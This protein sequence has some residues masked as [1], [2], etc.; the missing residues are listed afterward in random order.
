MQQGVLL[1]EINH[2]SVT[3]LN[4]FFFIKPNTIVFKAKKKKKTDMEN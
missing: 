1:R 2:G 4:Y 3:I